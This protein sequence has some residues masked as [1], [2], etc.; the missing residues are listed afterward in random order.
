[1]LKEEAINAL[2]ALKE[3]KTPVIDKIPAELFIHGG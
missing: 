3:G 2:H 1:M